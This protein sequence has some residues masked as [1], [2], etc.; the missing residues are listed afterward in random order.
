MS[1]IP[2]IWVHH[3]R[4]LYEASSDERFDERAGDDQI[5]DFYPIKN[6]LKQFKFQ[7]ATNYR[8]MIFVNALPTHKT[9]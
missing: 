6:S 2:R 1:P 5:I 4:G 3:A 7:T 9:L 8:F